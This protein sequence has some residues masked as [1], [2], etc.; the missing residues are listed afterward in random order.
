VTLSSCSSNFCCGQREKFDSYEAATVY[1]QLG[2]KE[3][4]A[5]FLSAT[6]V[7]VVSYLS[8]PQ[9]HERPSFSYLL[10]CVMTCTSLWYLGRCPSCRAVDRPQQWLLKRSAAVCKDG[11]RTGKEGVAGPMPGGTVMAPRNVPTS[12]LTELQAATRHPSDPRP[13]NCDGV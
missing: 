11:R 6:F 2:V 12:F 3:R 8:V 9:L 5:R 1:L 4:P 13:N 10:G 7:P